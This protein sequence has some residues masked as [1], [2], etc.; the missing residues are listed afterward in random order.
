MLG[1]ADVVAPEAGQ[2]ALA[3]RFGR[4]RELVEVRDPFLER[5][6]RGRAVRVREV[7][8]ERLLQLEVVALQLATEALLEQRAEEV[9]ELTRRT[10]G[11]ESAVYDGKTATT[12]AMNIKDWRTPEEWLDLVDWP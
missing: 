10:E 3:L 9:R 1:L 6:D 4:D 2:E 11:I 12:Y 8:A 5:Q 7:D